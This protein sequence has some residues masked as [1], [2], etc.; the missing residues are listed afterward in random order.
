MQQQALSD[1]VQKTAILAHLKA[2]E[3]QLLLQIGID[4]SRI[5]RFSDLDDRGHL[6][7]CLATLDQILPSEYI[8]APFERLLDP[9]DG[10]L[11]EKQFAN[12]LEK[13]TETKNDYVTEFETFKHNILRS[14]LIATVFAQ[15]IQKSGSFCIYLKSIQE[16][17][18]AMTK[19]L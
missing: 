10:D 18:G 15:S 9:D 6:S 11:L 19:E 12:D 3:E 14:S 5:I 2:T 4:R 8:R 16:L 17:Y 7:S 1:T 13:V